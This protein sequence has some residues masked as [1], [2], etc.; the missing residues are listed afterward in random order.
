MA[1]H[2]GQSAVYHAA[3]LG[4]PLQAIIAKYLFIHIGKVSQFSCL[5]HDVIAHH[6]PYRLVC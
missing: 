2:E 6:I 1:D 5:M 4:N 3:K